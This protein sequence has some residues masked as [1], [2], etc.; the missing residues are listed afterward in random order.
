MNASE[1]RKRLY[2]S[3]PMSALVDRVLTGYHVDEEVRQTSIA[4][5]WATIVGPRV[6][7]RTRPGRVQEGVL[8]VRVDNS[9]WLHELSFLADEL[10]ERINRHLGDP[11]MVRQLRWIL[12]RDNSEE[13]VPLPP[14]VRAGPGELVQPRQAPPARA[15]EI[16]AQ[17]EAVEDEELR[18]LI[19]DVRER[20]DL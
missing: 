13:I 7:A 19:E 5:G 4:T 6:A 14:R 1:R 15:G 8:D 10:V 2:A 16:R 9:A 12:G 3:K 17:A 20:F 11:P 18:H